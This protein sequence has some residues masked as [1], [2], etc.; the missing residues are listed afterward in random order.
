MPL[1]K[2]A[3]G[4]RW[5]EMELL[6]P[7]TPE[8]VWHALATGPGMTAWFVRA[9]IE[10]RVGGAVSFDFGEKGSS[11][12]TVTGCEPP[13]RFAY[14]ERGWS[15]NAPPVATEIAVTARSGSI[16]H[17]RMVHSL[18]A[19]T[20]D[21]DDQLEGFE[22]G[23]PGFFEVLRLYLRHFPGAPAAAA[24][25]SRVC[26]TGEA[27]AW[28]KLLTGLGLAGANAGD[29]RRAPDGA[30]EFG[31]IVE[32]IHQDHQRRQVTLRLDHPGPG[33]ALVNTYTYAG[34]AHAAI[35]AYFYGADAKER[36]QRFRE[37]ATPWLERLLGRS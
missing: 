27:G 24:D 21:W 29:R 30:P 3:L 11:S 13:Y 4:R 8:Q 14:E 16:C 17:V 5:V 7:G 12:G 22:S 26:P 33:I 36:A 23:W 31:G 9:K 28:A 6:L 25:A 15:E 18:F 20:E 1:K 10:E 2:D 35:A 32:H 37:S 19:S 34:Q